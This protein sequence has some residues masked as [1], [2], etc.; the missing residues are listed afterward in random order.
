MPTGAVGRGFGRRGPVWLAVSSERRTSFSV[1]P[2]TS[3][4]R[5]WRWASSRTASAAACCSLTASRRTS[6]SAKAALDSSSSSSAVARA[7]ASVA[8]FSALLLAPGRGLEELVVGAGLL[9]DALA[10]DLALVAHL[11]E[12]GEQLVLAVPPAVEGAG[13][14]LGG[15]GS[16]RGDDL[17]REDGLAPVAQVDARGPGGGPPAPWP[18][19]RRRHPGR[20][21]P[22]SGRC[23]RFRVGSSRPSVQRF[24]LGAGRARPL[25][26]H[27]GW[28]LRFP[29]HIRSSQHASCGA[30]RHE[31]RLRPPTVARWASS[32][33][34]WSTENR[35]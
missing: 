2:A 6:A 7:L 28:F 29:R 4:S 3:S 5:S 33:P 8:A 14:V 21:R 34:S 24:A 12:G 31:K 18:A 10:G 22:G 26:A 23:G 27:R 35:V 17:G 30:A 20:G 1:R 11:L 25:S 19:P 15:D 13:R 16:R 32:C 9:A